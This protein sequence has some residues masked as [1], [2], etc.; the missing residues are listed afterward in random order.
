MIGGC[1][2]ATVRM[3]PARPVVRGRLRQRRDGPG[4]A[5]GEQRER[6]GQDPAGGERRRPADP[7]QR[8]GERRRREE[9]AERAAG[10]GQRRG[11][12]VAAVR[13][14]VR[15]D[16]EDVEEHAGVTRADER[17]AERS[18][19]SIDGL[20]ANSSSP[21]A[22]GHQPE[23]QRPAR[24]EPVGE[25]PRRDLASRGTRRA[26]RSTAPRSRSSMT[27]N[28]SA[29]VDRR[30]SQAHPMEDRHQ[31][32]GRSQRPHPPSRSHV[33]ASVSN[34][35]ACMHD[36]PRRVYAIGS[37]AMSGL[38]SGGH[39]GTSKTASSTARCPGGELI[40]E[41]EIAEALGMS[42][43]PVR[44]AFGQL[45]AEGL[46]RLYPEARRPG[47]AGLRRRDRGRDGDPLGDRALRD[48]A[49]HRAPR[50]RRGGARRVG[51]R[52]G[53]TSRSPSSSRPTARS[54]ARSSPAPTTQIL[55]VAVR[56]AARPPAPD[57]RRHRPLRRTPRAQHPRAR[58]ARGRDRRRATAPPP[59]ACSARTST[60]RS[61][62]CAAANRRACGGRTRRTD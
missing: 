59:R 46:L 45:E 30:H 10:R 8:G 47:R 13:E 12:R 14:P 26:A 54:T 35:Y 11:E 23:R 37:A 16:P 50:R 52:P 39:T 25:Q 62:R 49:D 3:R 28:R 27:P 9:L 1:A 31:I 2:G 33:R 44:A 34:M 42:R 55:L 41:G 38:A 17:A 51:R 15:G 43:T 18:P 40:S 58:R 24:A 4:P 57:G 36:T 56:L 21:S 53:R 61:K 60:A 29:R 22:H 5:D 6:G 7:G 19:S 32:E 48:R 20:T